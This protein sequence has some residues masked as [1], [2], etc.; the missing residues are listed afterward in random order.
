MSNDPQRLEDERHQGIPLDSSPS[1][2]SLLRWGVAAAAVAAGATVAW[3]QRR[4]HGEPAAAAEPVPGLWS[5]TFEQPGGGTLALGALRG[6]PLLV[7]FWATWCAP[8]VHELPMLQQF[9]AQQAARGWQVVGLAIDQPSAVRKFLDRMALDFP[10]G[11]AGL[12]GTDL[13][14]HL[15][16]AEGGL[17]FTVVFTANGTVR[18]RKMGQ[19]TQEELTQWAAAPA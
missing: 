11:L 16:N 14:R 15:G 5:Q 19:L 18:Q 13:A 12:G 6:K 1:R 7:N 4:P 8:C 10:I 3:R 2:R 17:P 9:H